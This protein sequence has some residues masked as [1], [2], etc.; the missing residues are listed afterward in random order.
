MTMVAELHERKRPP[1]QSLFCPPG[2]DCPHVVQQISPRERETFAEHFFGSFAIAL[3]ESRHE[4]L[5]IEKH[6]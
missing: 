6:G 1:A 2:T 5:L 3:G 4:D